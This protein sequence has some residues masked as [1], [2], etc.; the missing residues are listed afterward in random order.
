M[1]E[2]D[3]ICAR[4]GAEAWDRS[5]R[6]EIDRDVA[7]ADEDGDPGLRHDHD[8]SDDDS[9]SRLEARVLASDEM[10]RIDAEDNESWQWIEV[11]ING[12]QGFDPI[13]ASEGLANWIKAEGFSFVGVGEGENVVR[14]NRKK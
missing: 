13:G 10:M 2:I 1:S 7:C 3:F 14:F 9:L 6:A 8:W 12:G 11:G 5:D 4:C